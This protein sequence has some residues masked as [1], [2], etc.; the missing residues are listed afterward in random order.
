MVKIKIDRTDKNSKSWW[1]WLY[2]QPAS[3]D[4]RFNVCVGSGEYVSWYQIANIAG[5]TVVMLL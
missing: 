4:Q 2:M 5:L 1:W 3:K